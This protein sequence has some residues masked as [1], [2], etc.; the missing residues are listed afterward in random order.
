VIDSFAKLGTTPVAADQA[1]PEA[2]TAKLQEQID[3]WRPIIEAA[4]VTPQ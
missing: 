2:H 1:T 4:G 3:L